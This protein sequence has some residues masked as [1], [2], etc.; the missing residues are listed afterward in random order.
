V[1]PV[2]LLPDDLRPRRASGAL[3]GSSYLVVGML[4][5]LLVMAVV[6]VLSANQVNSHKSDL[7]EVKAQAAEAEARAARLAPYQ[8][9]AQ[10]K[11]TRIDSVKSLAGRRFDWERLMREV[12]LVLP[13]DTSLTDLSAATTGEAAAGATAAAPTDPAAADSVSPSL[14]LKGCAER[15]PE[16]ATLMVR[17]RRLYRASDVKLTESTRQDASGG[18]APVSTGGSTGCPQDTYLFDVT[19]TFAPTELQQD[20]PVPA[21]LGGGA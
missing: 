13:E 17:L 4:A 8:R 2:N 14:N 20:K 11:Q 10:I 7:V 19:V 18:A 16:V 6:Y 3:R 5:A 12:A 1:R 15:Q 9:F 21:R